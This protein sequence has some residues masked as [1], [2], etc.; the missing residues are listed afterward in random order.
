M[1]KYRKILTLVPLALII[2]LSIFFYS[3]SALG[4]K[5]ILESNNISLFV[6]PTF[7][8]IFFFILWLFSFK[9]EEDNHID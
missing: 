2:I 7:I 4:L 8:T 3:P 6:I 1:N 9:T 5:L